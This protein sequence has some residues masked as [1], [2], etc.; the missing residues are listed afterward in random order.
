MAKATQSKAIAPRRQGNV[1]AG[2]QA[3]AFMKGHEGKGTEKLDAADMEIPRLRIV[4]AIEQELIA[5]HEGLKPGDFFHTLT[6]TILPAPLKIVPI[7]VSKRVVLWRPRP[8]IDAGGILARADDGVHWVP[9]NK[10]FEVKI[11]KRGTKVKWKT[12]DTVEESGLMAWGTYDPQDENSQPAATLCY[13]Y[14]VD[15]PDHPELSP[16]VLM[17]QRGAVKPAKKWN[18]KI[19]VIGSRAP[20]YGQQYIMDSFLQPRSDNPAEKF[21]NYV[22]TADGFVEDEAIFKRNAQLAEQFEKKGVKVHDFE[23]QNDDTGGGGSEDDKAEA[24]RDQRTGRS[25]Y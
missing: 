13:V 6:E 19:N 3:P 24:P 7:H 23:N 16:C 20:I 9:A 15:L 12:A 14:V 11:D 21:H 22:F 10:E 8:P 18:S 2:N 25:R 5:S 4:N 17:L 1:T